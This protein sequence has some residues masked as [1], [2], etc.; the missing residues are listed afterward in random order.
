MPK[1]VERDQPADFAYRFDGALSERGSLDIEWSDV[2]GRVVE[3]RRIPFDLRD[4][5]EVVFSLDL[6]RAVTAGNEITAHL[7]FDGIDRS[8]GTGHRDNEVSASFI[9]PPTNGPWS[10]YQIIMW[11]GQTPA[12]YVALKKLGITAAMVQVG[13]RDETS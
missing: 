8:G 1:S 10:D 5:I 4:G 6:R 12:G 9:V 11:Q 2:V 3:R 7:S 13:R